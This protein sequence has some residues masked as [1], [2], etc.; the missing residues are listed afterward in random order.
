LEAFSYLSVLTSIVLALGITRIFAGVGAILEHRKSVRLYW[1]HMLWALN[2]LLFMSL[3][4]WILFRWREQQEWNF[5]L[6]GFLLLSPAISFLLSVILFPENIAD[7]DFK[8]HFMIIIS[9]SLVW[10]PYYR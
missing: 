8:Y 10:Q 9:G 2:L 5:F 6:F 4:W 7:H 3:Q 1:V